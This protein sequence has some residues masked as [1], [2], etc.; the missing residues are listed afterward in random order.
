MTRR[1]GGFDRSLGHS[2]GSATLEL[3]VLTPALLALVSLTI[4][5]GRITNSE[6]VVDSAARDAARAA[7]LERSV[8]TARSAAEDTVAASFADHHVTCRSVGVDVTGDYSAP[9]GTAASVR[10]V[11]GCRVSLS[12]VAL[13]GLPGSKTLRA[14]YTSV[15]DTYRG[16]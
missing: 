15:I 5:A 10:V 13:P 1:Q 16:R 3:V 14:D 8:D 7:S 9:V 4:A 2:V 11:V 6:A 12:D